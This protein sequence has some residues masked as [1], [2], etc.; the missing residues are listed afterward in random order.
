MAYSID[1][2]KV[3]SDTIIFLAGI[4]ML[5]TAPLALFALKLLIES[6]RDSK[7]VRQP[8]KA[9]AIKITGTAIGVCGMM[10]FAFALAVFILAA[11]S[12]P[13]DCYIANMSSQMRA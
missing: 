8:M 3:C 1:R 4:T 13:K 10:P 12:K 11:Y 6:N 9:R 7:N 5:T 2:R